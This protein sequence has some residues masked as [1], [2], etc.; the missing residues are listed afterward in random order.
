MRE[1]KFR[2]K[3]ENNGEWLYGGIEIN[4]QKHFAIIYDERTPYDNEYSVIPESVGQ[5]TGLNDKHGKEIYEGDVVQYHPAANA[6]VGRVVY[7]GSGFYV[8]DEFNGLLDDFATLGIEVIDNIHDN[9]E[10]IEGE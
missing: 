4:V 3:S 7:E 8:I 5:Y 9:P 6:G 1:I 2:G 10:L